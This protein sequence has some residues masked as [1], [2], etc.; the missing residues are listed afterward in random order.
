MK[1]GVLALQGDVREH[2][3]ALEEAGAAAVS[4]KHAD[5]LAMVDALVLPGGESTTIGKL[6]DRFG[7]SEERRVGKEC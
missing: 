1:V 7:R 4:V 2:A 3:R 5:D 6:L